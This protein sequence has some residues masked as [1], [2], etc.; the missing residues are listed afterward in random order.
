M[1]LSVVIVT[2]GRFE[3]FQRTLITAIQALPRDSEIVVLVNGIEHTDTVTWLE[4]FA[5]SRV[6]VSVLSRRAR[7]DARNR[8]IARARGKIIHILDDDVRVPLELFDRVMERFDRDESLDVLGGPNLT[9]GDTRWPASLFGAILCSAFVAPRVRFRYSPKGR[10]SATEHQLIL[11][12]LAFRRDTLFGSRGFWPNLKS[13]EENL[14]LHQLSRV[15]RRIEYD[16]KVFV[17]HERRKTLAGFLAQI[18]SYGTGRGQQTY[19]APTSLRGP[20]VL[21]PLAPVLL[22]FSIYWPSVLLAAVGVHQALAFAFSLATLE[23][24]ALGLRGMIGVPL[25]LLVHA[26]YVSGVWWGLAIAWS[27]RVGAGAAEPSRL[28]A[29]FQHSIPVKER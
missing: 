20:F 22:V 19:L 18:F 2:A 9:P 1:N 17:F 23:L 15:G 6:Q 14:L 26:V 12:N 7:S 3:L 27:S 28:S 10:S 25:S 21:A 13:N 16:P 11:C 5:D 24:R 29:T 4:S 8:A